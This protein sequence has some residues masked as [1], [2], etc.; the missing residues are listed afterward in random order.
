MPI[1]FCLLL[2]HVCKLTIST[3]VLISDGVCA[4]LSLIFL[5]Q[6]ANGVVG[7][8]EGGSFGQ[9]PRLEL[10]FFLVIGFLL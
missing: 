7:F 5:S 8:R 1:V 6:D 2:L 3:V 9:D 4:E 10:L